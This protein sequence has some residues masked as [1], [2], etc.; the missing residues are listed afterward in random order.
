LLRIRS[1]RNCGCGGCND[2][3]GC[4]S[5]TGTKRLKAWQLL[6]A[7]SAR[8]ETCARSLDGFDCGEDSASMSDDDI[9]FHMTNIAR[10]YRR[11]H[12]A[13]AYKLALWT[14]GDV[15]HRLKYSYI[16]GILCSE[17]LLD[18]TIIQLCSLFWLETPHFR[19][20]GWPKVF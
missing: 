15:R 19:N 7:D 8:N 1:C 4:N 9:C 14:T 13:T 6:Q 11:E 3:W 20:Q 2:R 16:F 5:R 18:A 10:S 17:R 12:R